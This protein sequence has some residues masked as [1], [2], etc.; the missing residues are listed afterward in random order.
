MTVFRWILALLFIAVVGKLTLGALAPRQKPPTAVQTTKATRATLTR[1]V[2][3][4]GKLEPASKVN[5]SSN[6]TGVLLDLK[7]VIGSQV[8]KG[9]YLGQIDTS[10]YQ[11]QVAQQRSQVG[12]AKSDVERLKG[13]LARLRKDAE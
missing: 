12:A 2:S 5:V 13:H 11:S 3:G 8:K 6:I 9:D 4:A 10:R 1:T 7:V